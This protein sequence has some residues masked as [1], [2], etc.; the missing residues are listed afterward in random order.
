[1]KGPPA[2]GVYD[3]GDIAIAP[4]GNVPHTYAA[5]DVVKRVAERLKMEMDLR[6]VDSMRPRFQSGPIALDGLRIELVSC[7]WDDSRLSM[8]AIVPHRD[9][10]APL[11][12]DFDIEYER[13]ETEEQLAECIVKSIANVI[14][15][16]VAEML[17]IRG[18][19]FDPHGRP[20]FFTML[21]R[22]VMDL[23]LKF[24]FSFVPGD[25]ADAIPT[26]EQLAALQT[27]IEEPKDG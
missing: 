26:S 16:E 20:P 11:S 2:T 6:I 25:I 22:R 14:A 23:D 7:E 17:F 9:T 8:R 10:G 4:D 19:R 21:P 3:E 27:A 5:S 13:C 24:G 18:K 1:M 15:H 12:L